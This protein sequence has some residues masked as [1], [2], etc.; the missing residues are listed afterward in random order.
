M[1][2]A[3]PLTQRAAWIALGRHLEEIRGTHLRTLF[4]GD[5]ARGE[6]LTAEGAGLYLDYSKN[7]VNDETLK[8]LVALAEECG[9]AERREAMF[10]GERINVSE[11]RPVLHVALRMPRDRSLIV[12]GRRR[13]QGSPPGAG[14]DERLLRAGPRRAV[15]RSHRKADPQRDQHRDR[16]L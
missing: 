6:R 15:A 8:L 10:G 3:H 13:G 16:R 5:P 11:D 7:R 4:A 12:D 14:S 9:L 1:A 2:T